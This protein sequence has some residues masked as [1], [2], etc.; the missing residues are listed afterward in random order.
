MTCECKTPNPKKHWLCNRASRSNSTLH[1]DKFK[2]IREKNGRTANATYISTCI[3]DDP[4]R[5]NKFLY[6]Y[7]KSKC[8]DNNGVSAL[9]ENGE[10]HILPNQKANALNRQFS[11]VFSPAPNSVPD[12]GPHKFVKMLDIVISETGVQNLLPNLK[13]NNNNIIIM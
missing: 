6:R 3:S 4:S 8:T 10:V 2:E 11:S 7:V 1:W 12:L 5:N 13:P 9:V